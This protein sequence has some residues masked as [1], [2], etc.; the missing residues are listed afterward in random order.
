MF[1]EE[2]ETRQ[3]V[4]IPNEDPDWEDEGPAWQRWQAQSD[5]ILQPPKAEIR[6]AEDVLEAARERDAEPEGA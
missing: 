3:D 6:P 4:I 2:L 1:R 5:A